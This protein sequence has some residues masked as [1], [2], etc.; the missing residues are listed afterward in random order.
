MGGLGPMA[1]QNYYFTECAPEK[2]QDA[3]DRCVNES[4]R[5][6]AMLDRRLAA[7]SCIAGDYSI[8]DMA[9]HAVYRATP[10]PATGSGQFPEPEALGLR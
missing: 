2:I 5:L 3:I 8:A 10:A 9:A 1:G 7:R 4:A 6:Y